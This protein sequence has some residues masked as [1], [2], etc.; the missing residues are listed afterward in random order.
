MEKKENKTGSLEAE[1][2][3]W[4]LLPIGVFLAVFIGGGILFRDFY[5][6]PAVAAFLTALM[7][8]FLQNRKVPFAQKIESAT[9]SMGEENVMVMCLILKK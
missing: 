2:H 7:V 1:A 8:A 3:L 6:I 5:A 4:G 9:K